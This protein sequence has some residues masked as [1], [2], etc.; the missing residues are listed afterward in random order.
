MYFILIKV[1]RVFYD[2]FFF[3]VCKMKEYKVLGFCMLCLGFLWIFIYGFFRFY[4][5][6]IILIR[7]QICFLKIRNNKWNIISIKL[8]WLLYVLNISKSI[9]MDLFF[10][11]FQSC[12]FFVQN[13]NCCFLFQGMIFLWKKI[14]DIIYLVILMF[15]GR[16]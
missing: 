10:F 7:C 14:L 3:C 6:I 16:L 15:I 13:I 1:R 11:V 8:V 5:K 9:C 2:L 12:L 4:L